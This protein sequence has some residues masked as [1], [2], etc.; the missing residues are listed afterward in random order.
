MS[1]QYDPG[2]APTATFPAVPG[3]AQ[4]TQEYVRLPEGGTARPAADHRQLDGTPAYTGNSRPRT[5]PP[6]AAARPAVK[7]G[8]WQDLARQPAKGIA[9]IW[10]LVA[11]GLVQRLLFPVLAAQSGVLVIMVPLVLLTAVGPAVIAG[12]TLYYNR[13]VTEAV[14]AGLIGSA[15]LATVFGIYLFAWAV[16]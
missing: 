4:P 15:L 14:K 6:A 2:Q 7:K 10:V 11:L 13:T 8:S 16:S 9:Y 12:T 1:N 3:P 5:A